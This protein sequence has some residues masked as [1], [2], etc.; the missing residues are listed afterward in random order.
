LTSTSRSEQDEIVQTLMQTTAN[1]NYMHES[2]DCN[3]PMQFTR[4]WFAWANALFGQ[5]IQEWAQPV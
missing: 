3:N 5:F 2:I 4:E 1:T